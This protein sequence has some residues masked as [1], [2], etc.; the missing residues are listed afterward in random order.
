MWTHLGSSYSTHYSHIVKWQPWN[1]RFLSVHRASGRIQT[2]RSSAPLCW[3][4]SPLHCAL[5]GTCSWRWRKEV[6]L[7]PKMQSACGHP[8]HGPWKI[9]KTTWTM[10]L[11][12]SGLGGCCVFNEIDVFI[13]CRGRL[14]VRMGWETSFSRTLFSWNPIPQSMAVWEPSGKHSLKGK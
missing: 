4:A 1:Y 6:T 8:F 5:A 12:M 13:L 11:I 9:N 3:P 7:L 14:K 2:P 10:T